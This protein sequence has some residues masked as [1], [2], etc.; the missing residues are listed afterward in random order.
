MARRFVGLVTRE[1]ERTGTVVEKYDV[2]RGA[3]DVAP[4]I[5][6]G[7][8]G[9]QVGF[10]WTNGVYLEL[11]A[12]LQAGSAAVPRASRAESSGREHRPAARASLRP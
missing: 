6:F 2:E 8:A 9:N 3:S 4:G 10:G 5:R 1:F 11:L 7:Y 12:G